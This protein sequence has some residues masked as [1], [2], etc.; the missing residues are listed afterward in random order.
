MVLWGFHVCFTAD[1]D[2]F[3]REKYTNQET[4][5]LLRFLKAFCTPGEIGMEEKG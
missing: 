5:P 3:W 1:P 2:I 4:S